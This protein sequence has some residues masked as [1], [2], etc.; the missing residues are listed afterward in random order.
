MAAPWWWLTSQ[1]A[2][3]PTAGAAQTM[4]STLPLPPLSLSGLP[5]LKKRKPLTQPLQPRW[6]HPY[7]RTSSPLH[8]PFTHGYGYTDLDLATLEYRSLAYTMSSGLTGLSCQFLAMDDLYTGKPEASTSH[9]LSTSTLPSIRLASLLS[10]ASGLATASSL[11]RTF[12]PLPALLNAHRHGR[13]SAQ[14]LA[15]RSY[16][17]SL[18]WVFQSLYGSTETRRA[19]RREPDCYSSLASRALERLSSELLATLNFTAERK[20]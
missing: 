14:H 16:V 18:P 1:K 2:G 3:T 11:P 6:P 12:Y 19:A 20:Y 10:T 13:S 9:E 17:K 8:G 5:A 4:A 15:M 7:P